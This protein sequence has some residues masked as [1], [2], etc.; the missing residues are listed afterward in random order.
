MS[1][2]ELENFCVVNFGAEVTCEEC[3]HAKECDDYIERHKRT[4]LFDC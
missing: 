3:P 4:P 2:K 1:D